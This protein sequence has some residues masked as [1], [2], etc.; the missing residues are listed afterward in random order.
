MVYT[1]L[2]PVPFGEFFPFSGPLNALYTWIFHLFGI[3]NFDPPPSGNVAEPL[4]L[5]GVLYGTYICYDSIFSW[6][7]RQ[8]VRGGA[9]VL[10]NVSN[11]GW[12]Q[13]WGVTQHFQMGR[14]RA[15]ETRRWVLRSVNKGI[16]G[17]ID[18]LGRPVSTL[19]SGE[20]VLHARYRVLG[21]ETVYVK[22]GDLPALLG[23]LALLGLAW[24]MQRRPLELSGARV[25]LH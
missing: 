14:L 4:R 2:K 7:A 11:D 8:M 18:D 22:L 9:Q 24:R 10:V 20:G 6:V 3:P 15:I 5:N 23:A 21:G 19:D 25:D 12:Y 17:V 16:L 13:G 1:K